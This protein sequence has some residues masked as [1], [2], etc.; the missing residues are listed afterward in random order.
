VEYARSLYDFASRYPE[1]RAADDGGLYTSNSSTD[2][3]AWAAIWL[4]LVN[5]SKNGAYLDA[6][7]T[8]S[9]PGSRS[10]PR[11]TSSSPDRPRVWVPA[12]RELAALLGRAVRAGV[13]AKL[14]QLMTARG[15]PMASEWVDMA[16]EMARLPQWAP[17]PPTASTS[18]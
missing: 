7:V 4:Y 3:L 11:V 8:G 18:T 6:V 1:T 2:D 16:R 17:P 9:A 15:D 12:G 5:P 14:A 10:A 13:I